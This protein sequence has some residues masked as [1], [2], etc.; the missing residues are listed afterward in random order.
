MHSFYKDE[1][2]RV[3]RFIQRYVSNVIRSFEKGSVTK[4]ERSEV[5]ASPSALN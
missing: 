1:F 4:W 3:A 2:L 5:E